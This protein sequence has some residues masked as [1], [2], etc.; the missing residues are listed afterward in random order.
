MATTHKILILGASYGSLLASKLLFARHTLKLVCLP[1]EVE[2]INQEG[3]RVRLP[4]KGREGLVEID[5][6]KLPGKLS[7]DGP[8]AVNPADYDLVALAMM[9]PQYRSPGVRELMEAIAK[10]KVPCMSIMNMPPLTFLKRIPGLNADACRAAYADPTVW[11]ALDPKLMTLCSPDPQAFRPPEEKVNVLQV[12]L[13]TNFKA[14]RFESDAHTA[15][16]RQLESDVEAARLEVD[17][18]KIELPVKLKVH[19]SI[20]VPLAKWPML[21]AGNYRCVQK[22]SMRSIKDAV[23]TDLEASRSVYDYVVKLCVALGAAEKDLVP[24]E[25]YAKAAESLQSPSSAARALFGGAPNIE[26]VDRLVQAIGAQKG[27]HNKVVDETVSLVDARLELNRK[28]A[29]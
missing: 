3:V 11:D 20:F 12:R 29:A 14:A 19:D 23:H 25:K 6:R 8:G 26:R 28:K 27:M 22:D 24:F 9:E 4:V 21:L 17:G 7:A 1:A 18:K 2:L 13:P 15:I 16:L 10:A 5:S